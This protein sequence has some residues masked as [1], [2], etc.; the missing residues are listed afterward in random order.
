MS[1]SC[2]I[3]FAILAPIKLVQNK[4]GDNLEL[5]WKGTTIAAAAP[6]VNRPIIISIT[7]FSLRNKIRK[8]IMQHSSKR[9]PIMGYIMFESTT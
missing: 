2:R 4:M 1:K 8:I 7:A 3:R 9:S 6:I 5:K